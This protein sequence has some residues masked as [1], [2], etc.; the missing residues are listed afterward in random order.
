MMKARSMLAR[1]M[2]VAAK[3]WVLGARR[4]T[5]VIASS[6]L[7]DSKHVNNIVLYLNRSSKT[8]RAHCN[9]ITLNGST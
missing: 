6:Y 7:E 3:R 9:L 2:A 8:K 1:I 5:S 4:F